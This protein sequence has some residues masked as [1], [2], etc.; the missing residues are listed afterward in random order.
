MIEKMSANTNALN[1]FEISVNDMP[2][3]RAFYEKAFDMSMVP[4]DMMDI[5]MCMFPSEPPHTGG[6]IVKG[7]MHKPSEEG[8]VIY[9]NANPDLQ[10][11]LDRIEIAGGK[12]RML[13]T[14]ISPENGYMAF[15]VDTEGNV[16]GLHS[17]E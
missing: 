15:F 1:W 8:A 5:Q 6:A 2:R 12:I 13:K 9:L 16:V 7:P 4:M 14:L 17:N 11:V 3:A 10:R